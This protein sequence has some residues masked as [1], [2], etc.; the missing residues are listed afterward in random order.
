MRFY[1]FSGF[2]Y[3]IIN[4]L[5]SCGTPS[6]ETKNFPFDLPKYPQSPSDSSL[7][8][9]LV[10]EAENAPDIFEP[11]HNFEELAY[12]NTQESLKTDQKLIKFWV[13]HFDTTLV[14]DSLQQAQAMA[15]VELQAT[16]LELKYLQQHIE[17]LEYMPLEAQQKPKFQQD[18]NDL[19]TKILKL[20]SKQDLFAKQISNLKKV[21]TNLPPSPQQFTII[22]RYII[23]NSSGLRVLYGAQLDYTPS[24]ELVSQK[25][26]KVNY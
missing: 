26:G 18:F 11:Q 3:L 21:T 22:C 17:I 20:E 25:M 16:S 13:N 7:F 10:Q 24:F 1:Y 5:V 19:N 4:F 23:Q 15:E 12:E 6:E 2:I 14:M 9:S 8:M